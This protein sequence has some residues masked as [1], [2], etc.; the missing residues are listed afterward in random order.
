MIELQEQQLSRATKGANMD[1]GTI[2]AVHLG[3]LIRLS[4]M[5]FMQD[6]TFFHV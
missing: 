3:S 1:R 6:P 4:R 5:L 2:I